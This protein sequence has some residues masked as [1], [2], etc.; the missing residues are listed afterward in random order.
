M[1]YELNIDLVEYD[2]ILYSISLYP[3]D[4][5][6]FL[7]YDY[8]SV[9]AR[10]LSDRLEDMGLF[11][12]VDLF[13]DDEERDN[14]NHP[15]LTGIDGYEEFVAWVHVMTL[16][17][18]HGGIFYRAGVRVSLERGSTLDNPILHWYT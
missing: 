15:F 9:P 17:R 16:A 4:P 2:A 5:A 14:Y 3:Q 7:G 10:V 13:R 8:G 12:H 1:R 11:Q 6:C 18:L